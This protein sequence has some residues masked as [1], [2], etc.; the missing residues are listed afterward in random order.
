M[1]HFNEYTPH[2]NLSEEE[3]IMHLT[4]NDCAE[5][6]SRFSGMNPDK[7]PKAALAYQSYDFHAD[8]DSSEKDSVFHVNANRIEMSL[9]QINGFYTLDIIFDSCED[10]TLKTMWARSQ[11]HH[12]N[13]VYQPDKT[14]IFYV[15]LVTQMPNDEGMVLTADILNPLAIYLIRRTPNELVPD[16]PVLDG[17]YSGGNTIRMLLHPELV[18]FR[19][20]EDSEEAS[21]LEEEEN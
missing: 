21:S 13:E 15:K 14:W 17:G 18:T 10:I 19:Y 7:T 4:V 2:S 12:S 8:E 16:Y 6:A 20:E 11:K 3:K 5:L 9:D 1:E